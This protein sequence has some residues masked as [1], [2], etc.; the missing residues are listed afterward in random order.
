MFYGVIVWLIGLSEKTVSNG[1]Q[2]KPKP[3]YNYV[4]N[5]SNEASDQ[6]PNIKYEMVNM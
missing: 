4:P 6:D 1:E 2:S 3:T 5:K